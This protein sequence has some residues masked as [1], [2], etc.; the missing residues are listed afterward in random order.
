MSSEPLPVSRG[1]IYFC[2]VLA[3]LALAAS[4]M[5][6]QKLSN[7]QEQLARQSHESG[8]NAVEARALAKQAQEQ[9][10]ET[11]AR[12]AMTENKLGEVALQRSQIEEL[13]QSMSRSRDE[14]MLVDI[15]SALRLAQQQAQLTGTTEPL[16]AA[17]RSADQR[18]ERGGQ[19]RLSRVR[20]AVAHDIDRIKASSVPDVP[21][22]L[23]KLD[24]LVRQVDELPLANAV[25]GAGAGASAPARKAEPP[26][27]LAWWE[28][29]LGDL[30]DEARNLVR[31]SRIDQP[32]AVLL[33]PEHAF[34][35]RENLKLKLLNARLALLSRQTDAARADVASSQAALRKYFDPAS[36]KTQVA[37]A[38][39]QQ[40]QSQLRTVE[41]P[42]IDETLA[43]LATA[44]AGR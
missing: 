9:V 32:E 13:V 26:P 36:R 38:L 40:V 19:P 16:L 28:R 37:V 23:V 30:R 12:L 2:L 33:A 8:N 18:L 27:K 39:L 10:R 22:V 24:E 42:R 3:A 5:L 44:A 4:A 6:W 31:V 25:A 20:A 21:A 11:A 29:A 1:L 34:F 17:L 15:E 14:N 43:V 41:L 35:L 7:I